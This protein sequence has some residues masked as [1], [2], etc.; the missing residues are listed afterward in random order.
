M[1]VEEQFRDPEALARFVTPLAVALLVWTLAAIVSADIKPSLPLRCR[2][3]G[4][5]QSFVTIGTRAVAQASFSA[6]FGGE[7]VPLILELPTLRTLRL[8]DASR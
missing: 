8:L 7:S 4:P 6:R 2:R 3:K 5:R 1:A